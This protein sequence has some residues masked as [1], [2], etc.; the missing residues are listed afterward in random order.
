MKISLR[1]WKCLRWL[2]LSPPLSWSH[3]RMEAGGVV[4]VVVVV[5]VDLGQLG[6]REIHMARAGNVTR[7]DGLLWLESRGGKTESGGG[8]EGKGGAS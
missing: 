1:K 2:E 8:K 4:E 6:S 3:V 7:Q 5:G